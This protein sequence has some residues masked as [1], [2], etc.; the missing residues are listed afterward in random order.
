MSGL[1]EGEGDL[2]LVNF[3]NPTLF[4][5]LG[6]HIHFSIAHAYRLGEL[7]SDGSS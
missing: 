2:D 3:L 6:V 7:R 4:P 1:V 5:A